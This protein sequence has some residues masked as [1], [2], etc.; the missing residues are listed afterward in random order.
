MLYNCIHMA[1]VG[2]KGLKWPVLILSG[3]VKISLLPQ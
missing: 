1:A 3:L 2:V